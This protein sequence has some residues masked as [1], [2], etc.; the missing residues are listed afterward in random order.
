M[1]RRRVGALSLVEGTAH[2]EPP[3]E[4][5]GCLRTA[6]STRPRARPS[7]PLRARRWEAASR[8]KPKPHPALPSR[9]ATSSTRWDRSGGAGNGVK[10]T[11]SP[12]ATAV[13]SRL[14]TNLEPA[15][16]ASR[17]SRPALMAS[18]PISLPVRPSLRLGRLRQMCA[19]SCSWTSTA[20]LC[21]V[22]KRPCRQKARNWSRGYLGV[23]AGRLAPFPAHLVKQPGKPVK[24]D[25]LQ[26]IGGQSTKIRTRLDWPPVVGMSGPQ[27]HSVPRRLE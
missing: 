18:R 24:L 16:W 8:A 3:D 1:S 11:C 23:D 5:L 7:C 10:S 2:D 12:P 17:L 9:P 14:P 15:R 20:R 26:H 25:V 21:A 22:T 19:W 4:Q 6:L 27:R 13:A